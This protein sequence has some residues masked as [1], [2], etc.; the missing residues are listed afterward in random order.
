VSKPTARG[1]CRNSASADAASATSAAIARWKRPAAVPWLVIVG[2]RGARRWESLKTAL[3]TRINPVFGD[4][5][6]GSIT[7]SEVQ[8]WVAT[9]AAELKP[10]SVLNY[11]QVFAQVLDFAEI[12]PNPARHK[13]V[14]L[15]YRDIEEAAPPST[16]H[17]L[18][19]VEHLSRRLKLP[20]IFLE[21]TAAR[22]SELRA[23]EWGDVDVD[24]SRIRSRGVKGRRGTR[25][26]LWRQVPVWLLEVLLQTV[27]PDDRTA[28]R[29]LFP[30]LRE[31]T[32]CATQS[33]APHAP[34][35]CR[36]IHRTICATVAARF[37][38]RQG[39][40]RASSRNG[41]ATRTLR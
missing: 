41:W 20:A 31:G 22:V 34:P 1:P 19:I 4:R 36:C 27:P 26:V 37:G 25:R 35:A 24:G 18:A 29:K 39:C 14:K 17:F 6:P 23:W 16:D 10:R 15:P 3:R 2:S 9:L 8:E 7:A 13:L 40:R 33:L 11:W 30:G 38:T 32:R 5:S 28:E 12:E 21:Q